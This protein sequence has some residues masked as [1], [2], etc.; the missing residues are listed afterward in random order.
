VSTPLTLSR[1]L[2]LASIVLSA[3]LFGG[4]RDWTIEVIRWLLLAMTALFLTGLVLRRRWPRVPW[5]VLLPSLFLL[6][7]GWFMLWNASRRFIPGV[8]LFVD[9]PQR[10]PGWPGFWDASL[11]LQ[12]VLLM[13]GLLGALWVT[14]DLAANRQWRNRV[15]VTLAAT[16]LSMVVLG[17]AQRFTDAPGIFWSPYR[18]VGET[19]FATFRYHANAGA[20]INLVLPF[21]VALAARDF[22]RDGAE[23]S[24]VFWTLAS[25]VTA[26]C[27]FINTSRAANLV[28][29]L[30]LIG[31][32]A[33]IAAARLRTLRTRR[34]LAFS[35]IVLGL[36]AAAALMALSFGIDRS[37]GRWERS[38][39]WDQERA[40]NYELLV[41]E[42]IP[43]AG[44]WGY[45]PG[46]FEPVFDPRRQMIG[47]TAGVW[48]QAHSDILQTPVDYGWAGAAA[49]T[50]LLGGALVVATLGARRHGRKPDETEILSM[51]CA[52]ALAGVSLH[53][54][55]DFPLQIS[56]LQLY[57]MVVAGLAWGSAAPVW[58]GKRLAVGRR[59]SSVFEDNQQA[60]D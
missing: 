51:A 22:Y 24:R 57:A 50:I 11:T 46:T 60:T 21:I 54:L 47:K 15:W 34:I 19:F 33:W 27:G 59:Q 53:A 49:W 8:Q 12:P 26:A 9:V 17:V 18:Y 43:A 41:E 20:Y 45:G 2:L 1:W 35:S 56:S 23:K 39:F 48:A 4:T 42:F 31:M 25:F 16:G 38:G 13:S 55:V 10:L 5:V 30:L 40:L 44:W 37:V 14:C 6:L 28:C 52:F 29:A 7:Q 3:W 36:I 58:R 32:T